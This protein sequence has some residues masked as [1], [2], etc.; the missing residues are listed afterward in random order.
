VEKILYVT[1]DKHSFITRSGALLRSGYRVS[2]PRLAEDAIP[3]AASNDFFAVVIGNSV[4]QKDRA[5]V[6]SNIRKM[7]PGQ[8]IVYVTNI[9][10]D[11]EPEADT[12]IDVSQDFGKLLH[13]LHEL[14]Q[15]LGRPVKVDSAR[16]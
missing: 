1:Y 13:H 4:L 15:Q 9:S 6:I 14:E 10:G 12:S 7:K 3:L 11:E 16:S 2:S 8:I 5:H